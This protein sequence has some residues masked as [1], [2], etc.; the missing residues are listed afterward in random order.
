MKNGILTK[1]SVALLAALPAVAFCDVQGTSPAPM[2][3]DIALDISL[4]HESNRHD[5]SSLQT[6]GL[7]GETVVDSVRQQST[8]SWALCQPTQL[9]N[10]RCPSQQTLATVTD[11]TMKVI[12]TS[13][14][15]DGKVLLDLS[16]IKGR[17]QDVESGGVARDGSIVSYKG[18]FELT[19]DK[20]MSFAVRHGWTATVIAKVLPFENPASSFQKTVPG[21]ASEGRKVEQ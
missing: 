13:H 9:S 6:L 8:T 14:V 10:D 5:D 15:Q 20:P 11:S 7:E 12:A 19:P 16:L 2:I 3:N 4:S 1:L 21:N 18:T 17:T